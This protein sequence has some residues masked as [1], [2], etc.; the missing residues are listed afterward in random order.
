MVCTVH[1]GKVTINNYLNTPS[2]YSSDDITLVTITLCFKYYLRHCMDGVCC[3][4][5]DNKHRE[6]TTNTD[7][8]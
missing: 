5:G 4:C 1:A 7:W 8:L 3:M 2:F 6:V